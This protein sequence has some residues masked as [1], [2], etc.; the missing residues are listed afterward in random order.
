[1]S[2]LPGA[3]GAPGDKGDVGEPGKDGLAGKQET[4]FVTFSRGHLGLLEHD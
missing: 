1:M 3:E 2:G 4:V